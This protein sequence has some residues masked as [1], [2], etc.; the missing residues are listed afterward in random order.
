MIFLHPLILGAGLACVGI[1]IL[2][3]LVMRRRRRPILWG[4]MR[5]LIEAYRKHQKRLRLEQILLLATRCLLVALLAM[6]LAR[7]VIGEGNPFS[8][9]GPSTVYFLLDT[10]LASSADRD[11][12]TTALDRHKAAARSILGTLD[13]GRGDRAGL[14]TLDGPARALVVP[15]S[16]DLSGVRDMIDALEST[17]AA[18]DLRGG[19]AAL[20]DV[21]ASSPP[22]ERQGVRAIVLSEF[23]A[24]SARVDH[25]L[26]ALGTPVRLSASAPAA[27]GADNI[28]I[29]GVDPLRSIVLGAS[30]LG[31]DQAIV[32]LLRSGPWTGAPGV[33]RIS[34]KLERAG[35]SLGAG[36]GLA[37]W[38]PGQ[39]TASASITLSLTSP[40]RDS[41]DTPAALIATIDDDAIPGDNTFR[42]PIDFR[43]SLAVGVVFERRF[44]ET[45]GV[46]GFAQPDWVR[47]ALDPG[48]S[49]VEWRDRAAGAALEAVAI[50]PASVD[51]P[52]LAGLAA[53]AIA[54]PDAVD[55]AGWRAL[56]A[57]ADAGG[58]VVVLPNPDAEAQPWGGALASAFGLPWNIAGERSDADATPRWGPAADRLFSL[59][60]AEFPEMARAVRISRVIAVEAPAAD[61][62]LTLDDAASTPLLL[63]ARPGTPA[64]GPRPTTADRG[65]VILMTTA[66]DF[67]WTDLPA[68]PLLVPLV[69]EIV[70]QG[71]GAAAGDRTI[72]AGNVPG[73][74]P[75]AAELVSD[76][77]ARLAIADGRTPDP[78]RR[79]GLWRIIDDRGGSARALGV[80]ADPDA[81]RGEP[82]H[83]DE[84]RAWLAS[85]GT[86][87]GAPPEWLGEGGSTSPRSAAIAAAT[88]RIALPLLLAALA[89]AIAEVFFARWFSHA[90]AGRAPA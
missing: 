75:R 76:S 78:I 48:A 80:N 57:F 16:P 61:A 36:V 23:L 59:L 79:A 47:L 82:M 55:P 15:A 89:L 77:G 58:L 43:D 73:L 32:T 62:L 87:G 13:V 65:L 71:A 11:G 67:A 18:M 45:S 28:A 29:T 74:P 66:L 20:R 19:A 69:Q 4:A 49:L 12:D 8:G 37:R 21:L 39:T 46:S 33:T 38:S 42:R 7:P 26:P 2:I 5:F 53:V 56:R 27:E 31:E 1:P 70:R 72:V 84:V 40:D 44:G 9:L 68:K 54:R 22:D 88:D 17:E 51:A 34:L 14:I 24:G 52:H 30:G 10:S 35:D 3:H 90:R 60:A 25:E 63:A 85:M 83:P 81:G 50:D 86:N 41:A 6:A 64:G